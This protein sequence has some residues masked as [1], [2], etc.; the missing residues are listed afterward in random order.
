[1]QRRARRHQPNPAAHVRRRIVSRPPLADVD[2]LR[3]EGRV[4]LR[5]TQRRDPQPPPERRHEF[6]AIVAAPPAGHRERL[7]FRRITQCPQFR[8][9]PIH[10][11]DV[12]RTP[13]E[14]RSEVVAQLLE[15]RV[16]GRRSSG[17][18]RR[19]QRDGQQAG[20]RQTGLEFTAAPHR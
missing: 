2:G 11:G 16:G 5:V 12:G 20:E 9:E 13:G 10:R 18:G 3:L 15:Q 19:R 8:R 6:H 7:F 17:A 4:R 14:P 1:L